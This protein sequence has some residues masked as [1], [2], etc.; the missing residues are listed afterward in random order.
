MFSLSFGE[1]LVIGAVLLILVK[2]E[3][4]PGILRKIGKLFG[5]AKKIKEELKQMAELKTKEDPENDNDK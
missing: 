4:L 5:E 3:E 1:I 2:P